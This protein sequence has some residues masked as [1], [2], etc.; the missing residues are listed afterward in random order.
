MKTTIA[1]KGVRVELDV[2]IAMDATFIRRLLLEDIYL[3][4]AMLCAIE[5]DDKRGE[6]ASSRPHFHVHFLY[7]IALLYDGRYILQQQ[8]LNFLC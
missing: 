6:M 2:S 7:H 8:H 1:K 3:A 4:L 5:K